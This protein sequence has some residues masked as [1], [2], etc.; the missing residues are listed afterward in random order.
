MSGG[1]VPPRVSIGMPLYNAERF[2][3]QTLDS[4]LG[5]SFTDFE[6]IVSDNA[7]T[8]AT[9]ELVRER[10][11]IDPR[12]RLFRHEENQGAAA[13][14]N[15]AL[16]KARADYFKWAAYDDLLDQRF[17]ARCVAALDEAPE[18]VVLV[19]PKT[20]IIDSNGRVMETYD[21]KLDLRMSR[22]S[23]RLRKL[24]LDLTLSN[25]I[26]GLLRKDAL[27]RTRR[28]GN[29]NEAD[30]VTLAELALEGQFWE[31]PEPLFLRRMHP[32]V[33]TARSRSAREVASW[34]DPTNRR[35]LF[36]MPKTRLFLEHFVAIARSDLGLA[37]KLR[38][39]S[40]FVGA[41]VAR[42]RRNR[43]TRKAFLQRLSEVEAESQRLKDQAA[44]RLEIGAPGASAEG[45]GDS[46]DPAL[47]AQSRQAVLRDANAHHRKG[48]YELAIAGYDRLLEERPEH[49]DALHLKGAAMAQAGQIEEAIPV[50]TKAFGLKPDRRTSE[51]TRRNALIAMG[52]AGEVATAGGVTYREGKQAVPALLAWG[53]ALT[54]LERYEEAL[55]FAEH[56][57]RIEGSNA[58]GHFQRGLAQERLGKREPALVS[59]EAAARL[60]PKMVQAHIRISNQRNGRGEW[61]AAIESLE[62]ALALEPEN[63]AA[64]GNLVMA[65]RI[66]CDWR[67]DEAWMKRLLGACNNAVKHRQAAPINPS[68]AQNL[69]FSGK[70]LRA[71]SERHAH[72]LFDGLASVRQRLDLG[73]EGRAVSKRRLRVAYMSEGFRDFPT[74]HLIQR[75]F[76]HHDR[77]RFEIFA[78]SYGPDDGS[79]YRRRIAETVDRFVD[80]R[81]ESDEEA[82]KRIHADGIDILVDLKGY[83]VNARP[84]IAALRPAP[85]QVS[86]LGYPGT[87]GCRA[88]DYV[89]VD[90]VVVPP[91]DAGDFSEALVH[92][93]NCYQVN[94]DEQPISDRPMSRAEHGLRDDGFVFCC[95]NK[96]Y[97]LD[98]QIFTLWMS[99]LRDV[100]GS[101]LWL[102]ADTELARRNLRAEA[103][104]RGI[105]PERLVFAGRLEKS[106][107]L[108]RHRLA[109]L[110]LDTRVYSA[111]TT[112][113]DA[114]WSGLPLIAWPAPTFHGRVAA[115]LLTNIGLSEMIVDS[116]EAYRQMAIGLANDPARLAA[117]RKELRTRRDN[118]RLFDTA[119]FALGLE[120][121]YRVMWDSYLAGRH[122]QPIAIAD[123]ELPSGSGRGAPAA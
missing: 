17:L 32:E 62:R 14:Y 6:L 42:T 88:V 91:A 25:A 96:G 30:R 105:D 41:S 107:H 110:F 44:G 87:W 7:S 23:E 95:F 46:D 10:L 89:L 40:A 104:G 76:A 31:L 26:F 2:L 43:V 71:L 36:L 59:Y 74:S 81:D 117:L 33:S 97:K 73:F 21:D 54:R 114:L 84:R 11:A 45:E 120:A 48:R 101:V 9:A 67:D 122:P 80:I 24:I 35:R 68:F 123:D 60:D 55:G 47:A 85:I 1:G 18:D 78:Y 3:P 94:D 61:E 75:L 83:T 69:P 63:A 77:G 13:N 5:Q 100:P 109:D 15:F 49:I 51:K 92:L 65:K 38:C 113:T 53:A 57:L 64:I 102:F 70:L 79:S 106:L 37:E 4:I 119:R 66:I 118:C 8:D 19:Y 29:Y 34:F 58:L 16:E 72:R 121:A 50:L 27:L 86:Y 12:V 56:A 99:I 98:P 111:H 116:P 52:A 82:A 22:P 93:P 103:A 90:R 112:G 108:A 28:H 20:Q 115:S 39:A